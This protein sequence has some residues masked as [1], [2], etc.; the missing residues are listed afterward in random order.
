MNFEPILHYPCCNGTS[1]KSLTCKTYA[2]FASRNR[3]Y[4]SR[5]LLKHFKVY[6]LFMFISSYKEVVAL[7]YAVSYDYFSQKG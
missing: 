5:V 1:F 3:Y 6:S 4:S 7:Q 2:S